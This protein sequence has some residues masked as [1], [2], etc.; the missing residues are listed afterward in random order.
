MRVFNRYIISLALAFGAVN[1]LLALFG[2]DNVTTYLIV[3]AIV[4]LIISLLYVYLNPRARR[5]LATMGTV[6]FGG[7]LVFVAM[8]V[9]EVIG[10]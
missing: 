10:R 9:I 4:Y 1:S 8:R 5:I 6:L 2:Q 7:F 3:N